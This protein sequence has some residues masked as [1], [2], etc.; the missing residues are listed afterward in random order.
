MVCPLIRWA[1]WGPRRW[2]CRRDGRHRAACRARGDRHRE[3]LFPAHRLHR[4]E[5]VPPRADWFRW[6]RRIHPAN[7][8]R[9]PH[10]E[11]RHRCPE[12]RQ[13]DSAADPRP[14]A[15][16]QEVSARIRCWAMDFVFFRHDLN[17]P[18]GRGNS[19]PWATRCEKRADSTHLFNEGLFAA[20]G[21]R[22]RNRACRA[23]PGGAR[24]ESRAGTPG[25]SHRCRCRSDP[26]PRR[27]G[28]G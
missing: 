9:P 22:P 16:R 28:P 8:G 20:P 3:A 26:G 21:R 25:N 27:P 24:P 19:N 4:P 13:V 6:A 7:R 12:G 10:G 1:D 11:D 23:R 15:S 14:C 5:A 2:C 17:P 18:I